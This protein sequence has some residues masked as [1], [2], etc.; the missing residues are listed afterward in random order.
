MRES[1]TPPQ[2]EFS[3]PCA[4]AFFLASSMLLLLSLLTA[5]VSAQEV[6]TAGAKNMD[7]KQSTPALLRQELTE[8]WYPAAVDRVHG[9]FHENFARDW[10]PRPDENKFLVYQRA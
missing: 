1:V 2:R 7:A 3:T 5:P 6:A 10:T 4:L 9:G 8:H